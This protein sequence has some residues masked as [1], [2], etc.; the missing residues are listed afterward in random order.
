MV[1]VADC[2]AGVLGSN[3][4]GPKRFSPW[5]YFTGKFFFTFLLFF[6]WI[7]GHG[8]GKKGGYFQLG[9]G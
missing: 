1:R 9:M 3:P 8:I 2:Q 4:G 5:I 7:N 6:I